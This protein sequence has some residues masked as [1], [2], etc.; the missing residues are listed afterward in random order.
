MNSE[1]RAATV[2]FFAV[3]AISHVQAPC[4]ESCQPLKK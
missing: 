4:L 2:L 1:L 3:M